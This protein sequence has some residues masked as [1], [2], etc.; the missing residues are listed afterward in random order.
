MEELRQKMRSAWKGFTRKPA[1]KGH[2]H[3]LGDGSERTEQPSTAPE[4][5]GT[6]APRAQTQNSPPGR[7]VPPQ[8]EYTEASGRKAGDAAASRAQAAETRGRFSASQTAPVPSRPAAAVAAPQEPVPSAGPSGRGGA[9][10]AH[11]SR[12]AGDHAKTDSPSALEPA[13]LL[14]VDAAVQSLSV[15]QEKDAVKAAVATLE[16]VCNN[17]LRDQESE[18]FRR[19]RIRNATVHAM[20]NR[21][22]CAM[23]LQ[24]LGFEQVE[25]ESRDAIKPDGDSDEPSA[26]DEFLILFPNDEKDI[27]AA[28]LK[29]V[30][31][32]LG[33]LSRHS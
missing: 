26:S 28:K 14:A 15:D 1:F 33:Q 20:H 31:S 11:G 24:L 30:L 2:G 25:L 7:R 16:R 4:T 3:K 6:A 5:R 10:D 27:E 9:N 21:E 23:L 17:I 18:K 32:Q 29:A 13:W 19:L 22:E 8:N 12:G